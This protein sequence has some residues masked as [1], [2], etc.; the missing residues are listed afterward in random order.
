MKT[1]K[2]IKDIKDKNTEL[3]KEAILCVSPYGSK[4]SEDMMDNLSQMVD[5][6]LDV[7]QE[8]VSIDYPDKAEDIRHAY[9]YV[10][11]DVRKIMPK[12]YS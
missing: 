4:I 12:I 3:L 7:L 5:D 8:A 6:I 9:G 11:A 2:E 1:E 10:R